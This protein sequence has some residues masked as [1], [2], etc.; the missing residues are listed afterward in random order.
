MAETTAHTEVPGG[1]KGVFP[2]F[3]KETFPTQL[4][5]LGITFILLYVMMA[6]VALPRIGSILEERRGHID[7]A[8]AEA[9]RFKRDS[10][11]AVAA[12]EKALAEARGKAHAIAGATRDKLNAEADERRKAIEAQLAEKLA[13]A[14]TTIADT[15]AKAMANVEA[16]ATEAASAIV[17]KLIG[18]TPS[19]DAVRAAVA[20][21]TRGGRA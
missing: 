2:P 11:A 20:D 9:E 5:W 12:Y 1:H 7:G 19:S 21:A 8:I 4:T 16:I 15:K 13:A 10:E 3:N 17:E 14:E 6:K 18:K